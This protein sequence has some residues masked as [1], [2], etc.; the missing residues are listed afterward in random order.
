MKFY[1][2]GPFYGRAVE[3][4]GDPRFSDGSPHFYTRVTCSGR[5]YPVRVEADGQVLVEVTD[6]EAARDIADDL[7]A[8]ANWSEGRDSRRRRG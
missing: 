6:P 7:Y 8:A 2:A 1:D 3:W 4:G 5:G